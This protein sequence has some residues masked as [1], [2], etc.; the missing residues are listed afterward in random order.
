MNS[1]LQNALDN[2]PLLAGTIIVGLSEQSWKDFD[3]PLNKYCAVFTSV[4]GSTLEAH[5]DTVESAIEVLT[6]KIAKDLKAPNG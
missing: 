2:P 1:R 5:S 4:Y 6:K 3:P